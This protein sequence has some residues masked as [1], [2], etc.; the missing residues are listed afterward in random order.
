MQLALLIVRFDVDRCGNEAFAKKPFYRP[1]IGLVTFD[2]REPEAIA[3][4]VKLLLRGEINR[5]DRV[6][7]EGLQRERFDFD[8]R[9]PLQQET[10]FVGLPGA[11]EEQRLLPVDRNL[12]RPA[13]AGEPEIQTNAV[14]I[15][16]PLA[17]QQKSRDQDVSCRNTLTSP[18][19]LLSSAL[20]V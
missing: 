1:D 5:A 10:G 17:G 9:C 6:A 19:I 4:A 16:G 7:V 14:G 15:V 13:R 18:H 3:R 12:A 8:P 11:Q 20:S 2:T